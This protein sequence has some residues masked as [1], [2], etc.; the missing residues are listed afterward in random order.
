MR[1]TIKCLILLFFYT[2]FGCG[3]QAIEDYYERPAWLKG[4]AYDVLKSTGNFKLFLAAADRTEYKELLQGKGL[5]TVFAPDD[6]AMQAYLQGKGV[7]GVEDLNQQDLEL[8]IGYH[9]L[10]YSY[11]KEELLNF[12]PRGTA[13]AGDKDPE[14][15]YYKHMTFAKHPPVEVVNSPGEPPITLYYKEKHLPV[16]STRLFSTLKVNGERNYKAFFPDSKW[17]GDDEKLYV[18]NAGVKEDGY[19]IPTDNGYLYYV[20]QVVKPL[21]TLFDAIIARGDE[22][23]LFLRLYNRFSSID[24]DA[25]VTLKYAP[26]GVDYYIFN[27]AGVPMIANEWT[28]NDGREISANSVQCNNAFVPNNQ[29]IIEFV[30][31]FFGLS[32]NSAA[33]ADQL[34][35]IPLL[36]IYFFVLNHVNRSTILFPEEIAEKSTI[37]GDKVEFNTLLHQEMCSNGVFYGIDKVIAPAMFKSVSGPL[38]QDNTHSIFTYILYRTGYVYQLINPA[39]QFS[40]FA[41]TD[42]ALN[43]MGIRLNMGT[44]RIGDE[45]FEEMTSIDADGQQTWKTME[46]MN[47]AGLVSAHVAMGEV[48]NFAGD[49]LY[50]P[51]REVASTV[52]AVDGGIR[53]ELPSSDPIE[54]K[55]IVGDWIN[56]KIYSIDNALGRQSLTVAGV[57]YD[58]PQY[59]KFFAQ[60]SLNGF[61]TGAGTATSP[62]DIKA[63]TEGAH[64]MVFAPTNDVLGSTVLTPDELRYCFVSL[65]DNSLR[66]YLLP[67]MMEAAGRYK[68][69]S[70]DPTLTTDF[71]LVYRNI[72]IEQPGEKLMRLIDEQDNAVNIVQGIPLFAKDGVIYEAESMLTIKP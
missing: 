28:N 33:D 58:N 41:P 45:T 31:E 35:Q 62:W 37:Y 65:E 18:A 15:I 68:T 3:E 71:Q 5:C 51:G 57:L 16:F 29:A 23:S 48:D 70:V 19:A 10:Q 47:I 72:D 20:D 32:M 50:F 26:P 59:S 64:V 40:V 53:G 55:E 2:L 7:A 8:L 67:G 66:Q 30:N 56:G 63:L 21:P 52:I 42:V 69:L 54:V 12:A 61:I 46:Y 44:D 34:S 6:E 24:K 14:G 43:S 25:A 49:T 36:S 38:Y 4:N 22:Y 1:G 39:L 17:Y 11:S 27:H 9:I 13:T 60:L